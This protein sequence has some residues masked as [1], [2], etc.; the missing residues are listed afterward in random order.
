MILR[1]RLAIN[2]A[3]ALLCGAA[4]IA[5]AD[6]GAGNPVN[7]PVY[8]RADAPI[9]ARVEDLL[10]RM[11]LEEK[12]AQL[13]SNSTLPPVPGLPVGPT[14][15]FGLLKNGVIDEAVARRSLADGM[16]AFNN[17]SF[18][19]KGLTAAEQAAQA[20]AIQ[21]WIVKNT[22]LGIPVLFQA[23]ALHGAV[24]SGA[25]AFPQAIGLGSTWDRELMRQMF[26]VVSRESRASGV[27]MVLA[28]VLDLSRDP[29][30]GR[31]EEM[32]SEDPYLVGEL[33]VAAVQGLQG[34]AP[35]I[36][37]THV[38][39]TAK[40]F[41]HG[42]PEN[43]TNTAPSDF[44]E[45][46]MRDTFLAPFEKAVKVGKIGAIMP[47]YNE[48]SG[49]IP[50]HVNSW[51]L[52]DILRQEWGFNGITNSDW[53]A[54]SELHANHGI[55]ASDADAGIQ[56]FNAG[57]D[58]ETPNGACFPALVDAVRTGKVHQQDLDAAVARVLALKFRAGLFEHPFTDTK[59]SSSIVGAQVNVP[60]ARKVADE[61]IVLL[62]NTDKL[63]PLDAAKI[64]K[65]AVI[66]P[67]ADK[68][69][70]GGYSGEPVYFVTVLDG[71][72]KRLGSSVDVS[73]A[74]GVRISEPDKDPASNKLVPYAAP[75]A[76]KDAALISQAVDTA[77]S[78]DVV[79]LVLGGNETITREA[80]G[81]MFGGKPSLGD[82]DDLELP[83]RQNELVREVIK[84]GKPTVAVLLNGRPLSIAQLNA[85]VPAIIEGWY[86]GQETGNAI[87][88]VLFGDVNPSGKLPVTIARSAG[89]LPVFYYKTPQARLGYV[90]NDNT[91]LYWFGYG[92]SFTTFS[93]GKPS[94]DRVQI[95]RD[96]AAKVSVTVT[97]SGS[98][99]GAEVV[100][101]YVHPKVSSVVQPVLRLAGFERIDLKAGE[102]KTA[103]FTVGPEQLAIWNRQ[104]KHVV[105]PG[106]VE[107]SVGG[108]AGQLS[109]VQ[110]EVVP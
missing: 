77:R 75:S 98:R 2:L 33:G 49:G 69:R 12:V 57:L 16:G 41:V 99:A 100:Q 3:N 5:Y 7:A 26:T 56:A 107:V 86:L 81:A 83:G 46:T 10:S 19:S 103:T 93:Y 104:M 34:L 15:A 64:R 4:S 70:L 55:V 31:V 80:F 1:T 48:N 101:L 72:R 79:V 28:P 61:S 109:S 24:V 90:F 62:K 9:Q 30:Y 6:T 94:L 18:G 65:L 63:L 32:Y 51:L 60:L 58:M 11:T 110:L 78:A 43:G 92:L 23:E 97:N 66:G 105:E 53:F 95:P 29:R 91:P 96:G 87:A 74:E 76:E 13:Q 21:S 67:N 8:K 73:F 85:S 59:R 89:Q 14:P 50:S 52:K 37:E 88:G 40:H 108:N 42:Q 45:R 47:S 68:V 25:T 84:L 82:T 36:D 22:R 106:V 102:M 44:S 17:V 35:T 27:A 38:I 20:N 71:I 39:A 54:V